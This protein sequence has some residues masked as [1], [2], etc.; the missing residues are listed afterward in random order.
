MKK[1]Q[2]I[3][4]CLKKENALDWTGK[5]SNLRACAREIVEQEIIYI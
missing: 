3:T 4:E 2:A 1:A 5:I